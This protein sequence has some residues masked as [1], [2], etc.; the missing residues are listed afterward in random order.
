MQKNYTTSSI[1]ETVRSGAKTYLGTFSNN[2]ITETGT[3]I[4]TPNENYVV[5]A[6]DFS[7]FNL[8]TD[9]KSVTFADSVKA[10][11][12]T[13]TVIATVTI[14]PSFTMP[15]ADNVVGI[16][17]YGDAKLFKSRT[18]DSTVIIE[19]NKITNDYGDINATATIT[20]ETDV[21]LVKTDDS[22][23]ISP[24]P[25]NPK[26]VYDIS[27]SVESSSS[28]TIATVHIKADD[29]YYFSKSPFLKSSFKDNIKFK[30][31]SIVRD[32]DSNITE[33]YYKLIY[34]N[35]R[36]SSLI[37]NIKAFLIYNAKIKN[38]QALTITNVSVGAPYVSQTGES[39]RIKIYGTPG[40]EFELTFTRRSTGASILSFSNST[41]LD[42]VLGSVSSLIGTIGNKGSYEFSQTFPSALILSTRANGSITN[43]TDH[44]FDSIENVLIGDRIITLSRASI[45]IGTDVLVTALQPG[46]V[47]NKLTFDTAFSLSDNNEAQFDRYDEYYL[48][49]KS[50]NSTVLG[51]NVNTLTPPQPATSDGSLERRDYNYMLYQC[52]R[53]NLKLT[54]SSA[55]TTHLELSGAADI[56]HTGYVNALASDLTHI[57][58]IP[59]TFN[60]SYSLTPKG[61]HSTI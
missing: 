18:L 31:S 34:K 56:V 23:G 6:K 39:R 26:V 10:Y 16:R 48:N 24:A 15:A 5:A 55:D 21:T 46:G 45:P 37:N 30:L 20:A 52:R 57:T 4:I 33:Y 54:A 3:I 58:S 28:S 1:K 9:I 2:L 11:D 50:L 36:N 19:H 8:P 41:M 49:I 60:I 7:V 27:K 29:G 42:P 35:T 40:S 59:K 38:T 51:P 25:K 14:D 12:L 43:G 17:L 44:V 22:I 61:G 53:P 13:N 47:A 32:S